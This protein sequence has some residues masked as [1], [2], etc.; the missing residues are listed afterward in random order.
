MMQDT[1]RSGSSLSER[2]GSAAR[3]DARMMSA[4]F[5]CGA[6][7]GPIGGFN[8]LTRG[9]QNP[10]IVLSLMSVGRPSSTAAARV[11]VSS[12]AAQN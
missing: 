6:D 10:S 7:A 11:I 12:N 2:R 1:R 3:D 4:S 9:L 8:Y 5:P